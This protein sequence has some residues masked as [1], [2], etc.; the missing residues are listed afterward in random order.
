MTIEQIVFGAIAFNFTLNAAAV[1]CSVVF[2]MRHTRKSDMNGAT[3]PYQCAHCDEHT[4][5]SAVHICGCCGKTNIEEE[6][7]KSNP[8]PK[9]GTLLSRANMR[10]VESNTNR[11]EDIERWISKQERIK[12]FE[13]NEKEVLKK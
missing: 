2:C 5:G 3:E 6:L 8:E 4:H 11:I 10:V 7:L 1:G 13:L 9:H 12:Q